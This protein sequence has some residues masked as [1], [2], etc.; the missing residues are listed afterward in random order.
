MDSSNVKD[1]KSKILF[2]EQIIGYVQTKLSITVDLKPSQVVSGRETGKTCHFLQLLSVIA[3]F[4]FFSQ[5]ASENVAPNGKDLTQTITG[6]S[7]TTHQDSVQESTVADQEEN[8]VNVSR[9]KAG[10]ENSTKRDEGH[11]FPTKANQSI[12]TSDTEQFEDTESISEQN[13]VCQNLSPVLKRV[14]NDDTERKSDEINE[15][16]IKESLGTIGFE[17]SERETIDGNT[18]FKKIDNN[19][20]FDDQQDHN[21]EKIC[22]DDRVPSQN[23]NLDPKKQN[24]VI[25]SLKDNVDESQLTQTNNIEETDALDYT[26][27][28]TYDRPKTARCKPPAIKE[29]NNIDIFED[30]VHLQTGLKPVIFVDDGIDVLRATQNLTKTKNVSKSTEK[31]MS[32]AENE[33]DFDE[34]KNK[35][36]FKLRAGILQ[37]RTGNIH[38]FSSSSASPNIKTVCAVI[39]RIANVVTPIGTRLDRIQLYLSQMGN[40]KNNWKYGAV[41]YLREIKE[42]KQRRSVMTEKL[43][44]KNKDVEKEISDIKKMITKIKKKIHNND[45]WIRKRLDQLS[46]T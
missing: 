19:R 37:K 8:L 12:S 4:D 35:D 2:L 1:K 14:D 42:S 45:A 21:Q 17:E 11:I 9:N 40:E 44:K 3:S 32:K 26:Q 28:V 29:L 23:S 41:Q 6:K 22:K 34:P 46:L 20:N 7:R 15:T 30:S 25:S 36:T 16:T 18:T 43:E 38:T 10:I 24:T 27:T 13:L 33:I 5:E 31:A 39:Q